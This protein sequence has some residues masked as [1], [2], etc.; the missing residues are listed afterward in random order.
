MAD[1]QLFYLHFR[2]LWKREVAAEDDL[3]GVILDL[4]SR[5]N[6]ILPSCGNDCGGRRRRQKEIRTILRPTASSGSLLLEHITRLMIWGNTFGLQ[7]TSTFKSIITVMDSIFSRIVPRYPYPLPFCPTFSDCID[8][9]LKSDIVNMWLWNMEHPPL[10]C[11]IFELMCNFWQYQSHPL[12]A[13]NNIIEALIENHTAIATLCIFGVYKP[14]FL[15]P[16]MFVT[17]RLD[18][19]AYAFKTVVDSDCLLNI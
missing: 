19:L 7:E 9:M 1:F 11:P 2:T 12:E 3:T 17:T 8:M 5:Y 10:D 4:L 15:S 14:F 18:D 16:S 6:K 13:Y